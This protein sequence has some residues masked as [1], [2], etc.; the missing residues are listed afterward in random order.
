MTFQHVTKKQMSEVDRISEKQFG[1][2]VLQMMENAGRNMSVLVNTIAKNEPKNITVIYGKGNNGG[3]GLAAARHLQIRG[4]K[5][6]LIPADPE[7]RLGENTK[8]Q[9]K[10]LKKSGLKNSKKPSK[11]QDMIIDALLGYNLKGE[12]HKEYLDLIDWANE[13]KQNNKTKI[14]SFDIPSGLNADTGKPAE[15]CIKADY[16][17]TLGLPKKSF[18]NRESKR[19][20][21]KLYVA[22]LGI[23]KEVFK[24]A[25][26]KVRKDLFSSGDIVKTN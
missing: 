4:H 8:Q 20:V 22:N 6:T 14:V 17:L 5:V 16:T 7:K 25:N 24:K 26:I 3:D 9:L 11:K 19:Y 23:P 2:P 1:L 12:P 15:S 18:Q 13:Q 21:G 10:I